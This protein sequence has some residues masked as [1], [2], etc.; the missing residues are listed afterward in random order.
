MESAIGLKAWVEPFIAKC[1]EAFSP[2]ALFSTRTKK[3]PSIWQNNDSE[4]VYSIGEAAE[5]CLRRKQLSGRLGLK[6][7]SAEQYVM[8]RIL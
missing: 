7:L 4:L 3:F 8:R 5:Q 2:M 1:A 6:G